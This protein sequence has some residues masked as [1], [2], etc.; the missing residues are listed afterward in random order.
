MWRIRRGM[1]LSGLAR[2]ADIS[3]S[4]I[5]E[6][7]R[8]HG[9]PS[10]DT[11]WS[12]ARTLN[13]PLGAFFVNNQSKSEADVR[14]LA[15]APVIASDGEDYVAQI[16]AGWQSRGEVELVIVTLASGARRNSRGN[17]PG[18]VERALCVKGE[19]E[20]GTVGGRSAVLREGDIMTFA[21][22]PPHYYWAPNGPGRL[23]VVQQ[24]PAYS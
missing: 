6:L 14:R 5:S 18:V 17:A 11:L 12:L 9:N 19:V 2:A 23:V 13:V 22:T 4:T 20:V 10:L 1:T 24:Y 7:E 8:G 21:A 16:M 3:K 15:E